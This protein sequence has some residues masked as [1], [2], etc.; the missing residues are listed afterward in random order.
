MSKKLEVGDILIAVDDVEW[1]DSNGGKFL[2]KDKHYTVI[3]TD[4]PDTDDLENIVPYQY[5]FVIIDD[6][7]YKHDFPY[8]C[9]DKDYYEY[10]FDTLKDRRDRKRVV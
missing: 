5:L 8:D 4:K 6:E 1:N 3:R 2:T 9:L 7:N 10:F